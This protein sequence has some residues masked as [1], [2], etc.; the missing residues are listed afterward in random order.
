MPSS[1]PP[2]FTT[3]L[4][5][6]FNISHPV[7]LAGMSV[8]AGPTLAAAV[9][10]AG[11]IGVIGGIHYT[12]RMLQEA[13]DDLKSQLENKDAPFGVDLA[14]PQVGGHAR[15]TNYDYT[16]GQLPAL[17]D[18][19]I[20]NKAA[21]FVCAVGVPPKDMVDKLHAA[22]ILVM[23]MVGHP[24]HVHKALAQGTPTFGKPDR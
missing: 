16:K 3:P 22:G 2:L 20:K 21:L 7:M 15:K 18:I 8:A 11:G 5:R 24:K 13:I 6:L 23:N 12:P 1:S 4:T 19:I 9:T 10:N 14:L 17:T